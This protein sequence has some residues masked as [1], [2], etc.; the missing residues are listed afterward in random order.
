MGQI[1]S[2]PNPVI[3]AAVILTVMSSTWLFY[4]SQRKQK[5]A[6]KD[7][8]GLSASYA[9][10]QTNPA[11]PPLEERK[12]ANRG[13]S[14]DL[15]NCNTH[16]IKKYGGNK[17][18]LYRKLSITGDTTDCQIKCPNRDGWAKIY[19]EVNLVKT[20][21]PAGISITGRCND[22]NKKVALPRIE[23]WFT[24]KCVGKNK[25]NHYGQCPVKF[26][27][28]VKK[29]KYQCFTGIDLYYTCSTKDGKKTF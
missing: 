12:S 8:S 11:D 9:A 16:W 26:A 29:T 5:N 2:S 14:N 13:T 3:K 27:D 21:G 24:N 17:Y 25:L 20:A 18:D 23:A 10:K 7:L 22:S 19:P 6:K 1:F 28:I 15:G 4:N